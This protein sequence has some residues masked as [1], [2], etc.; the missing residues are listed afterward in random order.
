MRDEPDFRDWFSEGELRPCPR[1]EQ[2]TLI[3]R[4]EQQTVDVCL[5]CGALTEELL[6][7]EPAT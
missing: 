7:R 1:C 6:P 5:S 2:Q 3:P 4:S